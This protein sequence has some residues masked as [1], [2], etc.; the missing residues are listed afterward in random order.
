VN[1]N[2]IPA[3]PLALALAR[4]HA[5]QSVDRG[6]EGA[7]KEHGDGS[8]SGHFEG[9]VFHHAHPHSRRHPAPR[10]ARRPMNRPLA[11]GAQQDDDEQIPSGDTPPLSGRSK[12]L[13]DQLDHGLTPDGDG[14]RDDSDDDQRGPE[15]RRAAAQFR[16]LTG[17]EVR[18]RAAREGVRK[19]MLSPAGKAESVPALARQALASIERH[20]AGGR[21]MR[22]RAT[23]LAQVCALLGAPQAKPAKATGMAGVREL[24]IDSPRNLPRSASNSECAKDLHCLLP[25]LLFNL[26]RPRTRQQTGR[27]MS[28][29]QVLTRMS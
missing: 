15:E 13:I 9:T 22:L 17:S 10:A 21:P 4:A 14:E 25:I 16:A 29:L 27:A 12:R 23:L 19:P 11:Q 26:E 3:N 7:R 1:Q 2:G 5:V 28:K 18:A 6:Q 24:L 8:A 20:G